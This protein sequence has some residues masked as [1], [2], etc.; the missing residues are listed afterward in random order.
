MLFRET[1]RHGDTKPARAEPG[2]PI[3]YVYVGY[4][5]LIISLD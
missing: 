2:L 4:K 1:L 5:L 3:K